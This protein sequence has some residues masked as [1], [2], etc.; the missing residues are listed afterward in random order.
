ME[1]TNE[2]GQVLAKAR[3]P[4]F[5]AGMARLHEL[6]G[7]HLGE[8]AEDAEVAIGI[9][10]YSGP[11][12]AYRATATVTAAAA[13]L[14]LGLKGRRDGVSDAGVGSDRVHVSSF[15]GRVHVTH[16]FSQ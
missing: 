16:P 4:E 13:A 6:T 3:L 1:V 10:T 11:W 14:R 12:M 9:E 2:Q 7:Q 15:L 8:G 5:V